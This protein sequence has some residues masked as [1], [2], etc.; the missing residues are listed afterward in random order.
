[1][2]VQRLHLR[3]LLFGYSGSW[4]RRLQLFYLMCISWQWPLWAVWMLALPFAILTDFWLGALSPAWGVAAYL[5]PSMGW[6]TLSAAIT[7]LET[8][9][10]YAEPLTLTSFL[11]RFG[12]AFPLAALGTGM[13][14]HQVNAFAEGLFGPLHSEFERTPKAASVTRRTMSVAPHAAR[15]SA[16]DRKLNHVKVHWPYVLGELFF[17]AYQLAWAAL[18]AFLGLFWCALA[19]VCVAMCTSYLVFF[20]GDHAGKVCFVLEQDRLLTRVQG[21]WRSVLESNLPI[22]LLL[23][24]MSFLLVL[25]SIGGQFSKFMLGHTFLKGFAPLFYVDMEH[26]IPT[27]FSVLLILLA[28]FLL[29]VIAILNGKRRIAHVSKWMIL[30]FGFLI[31]AF[32]EA[33]QVHERLNIPVG[34]L[35]GDGSLGVFYFPWVIPGIALVFVLGLFFLRFLLHLPAPTRFRFLM[36]AALYIGGAIGVELIGSRHAELHGYENWTYSMIATIEE[37]LEMAGLIVFIQALLS[38]CADGNNKARFRFSAQQVAAS[39]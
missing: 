23:G 29:M 27:Y 31:M 10:T 8:K 4:L 32:D 1:V 36:A 6:L 12:R 37:S 35:L 19:A 18:F 2:Q 9:Y 21:V 22:T 34:T 24:A 16:A 28:A 14:A 30:S 13:L 17:V 5:L 39:D 3:T 11:G 25:L 33:F 38:Y 20:Y 26:N 7:A 15:R